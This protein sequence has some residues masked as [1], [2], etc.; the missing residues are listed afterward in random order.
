[1]KFRTKKFVA[2]FLMLIVVLVACAGLITSLNG[3]VA[4]AD[5][6]G[7][8]NEP[9]KTT[10]YNSS[11][12][13][14][15]KEISE[16]GVTYDLD[17]RN[18]RA[19]MEEPQITVLTPGLGGTA[20][21]WSNA[22]PKVHEN[23]NGSGVT[24]FAYNEDSIIHQLY[25]KAGGDAYVYWAKMNKE[26]RFNLY[27]IINVENETY[28]ADY[29]KYE[30]NLTEVVRIEDV[31]KPIIIVFESS[32]PV[33]SNDTVYYEFNYM[34]SNIVY[35]V[36]LHNPGN[37]LPKVNLIGHSRGGITN[38]QYA[39]DHPDLVDKL[40]SLGTPYLGSEESLA[41]GE[42]VVGR[43][44]GLEDINTLSLSDGYYNRWNSNY[45]RLYSDIDVTAI[46]AIASVMFVSEAV[47]MVAEGTPLRVVLEILV[48]GILS[49]VPGRLAIGGAAA[50]GT[51][52]YALV[53]LFWPDIQNYFSYEQVGYVWDILSTHIE[54]II[55]P[56]WLGDILVPVDSA[57]GS[58]D[59]KSF[60]GFNRKIGVFDKFDGT[61]FN[62][63]CV[64]NLP[65]PHNLI[66]M[67]QRFIDAVLNEISFDD[68]VVSEF[69]YTEKQDGTIKIDSYY[70]IKNSN[71][72]IPSEIDGKIVTE[73]GTA[74]F[75]Y[76][77]LEDG[78]TQKVTI[79][80]TVIEI[81]DYAFL[82]NSG[83]KQVAFENGSQ[84]WRVGNSAFSGCNGLTSAVLP[85]GVEEI[86]SMAFANC[87]SLAGTF[88]LPTAMTDYGVCAFVG[89]D[90][91]TA[92]N[93]SAAN[94]HYTVMDGVLYDVDNTT[95]HGYPVG[96][97]GSNFVVPDTVTTISQYAFYGNESIVSVDLANVATIREG[98]FAEC[99][100][101]DTVLSES[102]NVIEGFAFEGTKWYE[103]NKNF[104]SI[105]NVVYS[106]MGEDANI[107][108]S[109]YFSISPYAAFGNSNIETITFNN[110]ARNI[111]AF[112]FASCENL[113]TV[114]L[115]NLNNIVYVGTSS[116]DKTADNLAIY[117][118]QRILNEYEDNE[119]WQQYTS[120]LE[121]HSTSVNYVLNGGNIGG[122]TSFISTVYYGG[123]MA[124]PE[125]V[126]TGYIF[127]GWY[128]SEDFSNDALADGKLWKDY[129]DN[130]VLYAKW[131]EGISEYT[132]TYHLNGGSMSFTSQIYTEKD[133]IVYP[134][135]ER[136]GYRFIGWYHD[137]QLSRYAGEGFAAGNKGDLTL[138]ARWDKEYELR[139]Y[140]GY[141]HDNPKS[142][143][144]VEVKKPMPLLDA[145]RD[146]YRFMG[147]YTTKDFI[148]SSKITSI[149]IDEINAAK[150]NIIDLYA[151]WE[152]LY[153][154][155][156]NT[157]GGTGVSSVIGIQGE[158]IK[159]PVTTKT[160]YRGT[161]VSWGYL[162]G[163]TL[164]SNF[165]YDY[166]IGNSN[167][168]LDV[169]WK[170][171]VFTVTLNPNGGVGGSTTAK[172]GDG[173]SATYTA[174]TRIGYTFNGYF[175]SITGSRN[176]DNEFRYKDGDGNIYIVNMNSNFNSSFIDGGA[177][178]RY[179]NYDMSIAVDVEQMEN[180]V[181]Y[182]CW[183]PNRYTVTIDKSGGTG[184]CDYFYAFYECRMT[185]FSSPKLDGYYYDHCEDPYG[186]EYF[187]YGPGMSMGP[188]YYVYKLTVDTVFKVYWGT[189]E[190]LYPELTIVGKSGGTWS[191]RITNNTALQITVYYNSK[192]CNFNDAKNW[193][194]LLDVKQIELKPHESVVVNINENWFA[195]SIAVSWHI[196]LVGRCVTYA[197]GLNTNGSMNI[198]HNII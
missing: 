86:G 155:S 127:E 54:G 134:I 110:A 75:A 102:A 17:V 51:G 175:T 80:A 35:D 185:G 39:L 123:Y 24:Y 88:V 107:D 151:R 73:I 81:G 113:D 83:L 188:S 159:L 14:N 158:S 161:W 74:A 121:V 79:P 174:P 46:G 68:T 172:I 9:D 84:L 189:T 31:S 168:T 197:D 183:V 117:V 114:Y 150:N 101:L 194:G 23:G 143:I 47:S 97:R 1:M 25:M 77:F 124:L 139:Y 59:G 66:T 89:C 165:G 178:I 170:Q 193:T 37:A 198:Y 5:F 26:G 49:T 145:E 122:Q 58:K 21:H 144:E 91:L 162:T 92:F 64:A 106:Y 7:Y 30:D 32:E 43:S 10:L 98:A 129:S 78:V 156:F 41:F 2:I 173:I 187:D 42:L 56:M 6:I 104:A 132:I 141:I 67:D 57:I 40:I 148:N 96:K 176:D 111:G 82:N 157:H 44:E 100:N 112:A 62:K 93:L 149:T 87:S 55:D 135:P 94:Q 61:D 125:P 53:E 12:T 3:F 179:F 190:E 177:G 29:E 76:A 186:N 70:G 160:G 90:N 133:E 13:Y 140:D 169:V 196:Y 195:T 45:E 18:D 85:S 108:F 153:V 72:V 131:V 103:N 192:M 38:L 119:L 19:V 99:A 154:V 65:V 22:Y 180:T 163:D 115:N 69:S 63:R 28:K 109:G 116:F 16:N 181:L 11:N 171:S 191:I 118:P 164:K 8:G 95:L 27:D 20:A 128:E 152:K 130:Y 34:L 182:A 184:G 105:G 48:D 4:N 146:G 33:G 138:Y 15:V 147:W 60:K 167:V 50:V 142:V 137:K 120:A 71:F 166:I 52:I 126:R 136:E 36:S